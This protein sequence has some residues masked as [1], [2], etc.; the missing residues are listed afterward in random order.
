MRAAVVILT[1]GD[2]D[3]RLAAAVASVRD[4]QGVPV[5]VVVVGNGCRPRVDGGVTLVVLADNV[6]VS[7]GRNAGWA[8]T[9]AEVVCFLDDDARFGS[10]TVVADAVQRLAVDPGL[11]VVSFRISD[12]EGR[13]VR[14]HI[15]MLGKRRPRRVARVTTFLGGA[16]AVRRGALEAVGGFPEEFFYGLEET[17]LAWRLLDRGFDLLYAGDLEVI[18]PVVAMSQRSGAIRHTARNRVLLARRRLPWV[19]A[20]VYL[21]VRMVLSLANLRSW[22]DLRS[23]V[24]GYRSGFRDPAGDRQPMRWSTVW[25]M[26]RLGRPPLL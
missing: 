20:A 10:A 11:A 7:R 19:L 5:E 9:T 1:M 4:Q 8:A 12:E 17:D 25:R 2:R 15:P 26:T 21:P 24:G 18:H 16:C 14:K 6:G 22:R 13:V 23:L 3:D